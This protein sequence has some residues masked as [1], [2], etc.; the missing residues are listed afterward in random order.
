MDNNKKLK[1]R[2]KITKQ[3]AKTSDLIHKKYHA[4]KTGKIEKN[5]TLE[6]HFKPI[7]EPLKQIENTI[8]DK[9]QPIKKEV[10]IVKDKNIKKKK[11]E[12]NEAVHEDDG[13]DHLV[14]II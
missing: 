7:V 2:E 3:I 6:K 10:N 11:P 14:M 4:L 8:N 1:D 5:I 12:D 9:S 13:N